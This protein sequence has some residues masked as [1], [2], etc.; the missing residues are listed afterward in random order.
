MKT[1]TLAAFTVACTVWVAHG[2]DW[3]NWRGPSHDGIST[4]AGWQSVWPASGP[5]RLWTAETGTGF[6]SITVR[7]GRAFTMG[8]N[9]K[10]DTVYCLDAATG[11]TVW[12]FDYPEKRAPKY[13]EGGPSA[14]PVVEG[15]R[16]FTFSK[17]GRV[18]CLNS[19]NGALVWN[20]DLADDLNLKAPKWG[21]AGSPLIDGER[22]L[23]NAGDA[24]VALNK[25][26]GEI[27]WE[28]GEG[29]PGYSTPVPFTSGSERCVALMG[30]ENFLVVRMGDGS[31]LW[32]YPWE[33]G[34]DV[35]A[36]DPLVID[37][38]RFFISS[39]YNHGCALLKLEK[40][41]P[42][43]LW[44][45]KN[46]RSHFASP[47]LWENHLYGI[48]NKEL[49]C[50]SLSS[51][52]VEWRE[53][54]VGK[55]SLMVAGGL[56]VVLSDRG[57]LAIAAP[58]PTEYEIISRAQV[59]GGKCWTVPVLSDGRIYCRNARGALVCLDVRQP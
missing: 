18:Y 38:D 4:E 47:V 33:T 50:L 30:K 2:T 54:S 23:L 11:E 57:E 37:G 21:F 34:P 40:T 26:T 59:L 10:R 13:Y 41:G 6:A 22:V 31:V 45:N 14:T 20:K 5:A 58:S 51:G 39:G 36:A 3:P 8:N 27:L 17:S 16:V 28:S 12:T 32:S 24:G 49:V 44:Q 48:D 46:M 25:T 29:P 1:E 7:K 9:D 55:G 43:V 42:T 56:M 35:N 52:A 53:R 15:D 19:T